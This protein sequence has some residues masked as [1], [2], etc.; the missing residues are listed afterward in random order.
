[1]SNQIYMC[2]TNAKNI[3]EL[4]TMERQSISNNNT[5]VWSLTNRL[6]EM[7]ISEINKNEMQGK[8]QT[9]IINPVMYLIYK[10]LYPYIYTFVI[11]VVLMFLMLIVLLVSF[12]IYL[13]K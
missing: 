9:K 1:M 13:R 10:Q 8:I 5:L 6:V 12:F 11:V 3:Q 7:I 2:Y 4:Y